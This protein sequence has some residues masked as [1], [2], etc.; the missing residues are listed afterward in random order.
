MLPTTLMW[1]RS[2]APA[3]WHVGDETRFTGHARSAVYRWY[4]DPASRRLYPEQDHEHHGRAYTAQLRATATREG[5]QSRSA[6]LA[7]V[8]LARSP[9]FAADWSRHEI[10]LGLL[11][12]ERK[13]S[14]HPQLG[15]LELHCQVLLDP[16]Q[17]QAL[18]IFTAAET[19]SQEKL[20]LLPAV[21]LIP[22]RGRFWRPGIAAASG[23]PASVAAR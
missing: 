14:L 23:Q 9:E 8:L 6:A 10:G 11:T 7:Q 22:Q 17:A 1:A 20:R 19:G 5:P 13:R 15:L 3:G 4:T 18:L 12:D 21:T 2:H 16:D